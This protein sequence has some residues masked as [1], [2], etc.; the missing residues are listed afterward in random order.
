LPQI[1]SEEELLSNITKGLQ[2]LYDK[3]QKSQEN[4]A[5]VGNLLGSEK[6]KEA[7]PAGSDSLKS[8]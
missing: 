7:L 8:G 3:V 6:D 2:V 4:A 5:V 1:P